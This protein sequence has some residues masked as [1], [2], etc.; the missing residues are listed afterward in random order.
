MS[1][2]SP[3]RESLCTECGQV[4]PTIAN[5]CPSCGTFK[6]RSKMPATSS[7]PKL[8]PFYEGGGLVQVGIFGSFTVLIVLGAILIAPEFLIGLALL[9]VGYALLAGVLDP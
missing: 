2:A 9:V 1:K 7:A 5:R 8:S 3:K 6:D 4:T